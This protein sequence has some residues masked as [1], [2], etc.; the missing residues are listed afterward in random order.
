M[1]CYLFYLGDPSVDNYL[2]HRVNLFSLGEL[3]SEIE[4]YETKE[5]AKEAFSKDMKIMWSGEAADDIKEVKVYCE[6]E[7]DN[8]D[9]LTIT[10]ITEDKHHNAILLKFQI[11]DID[12]WNALILKIKKEVS[13]QPL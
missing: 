12:E 7:Y 10:K 4:L 3:E 8:N 11:D 1:N 2:P 5:Q 13:L 9:N 6:Y